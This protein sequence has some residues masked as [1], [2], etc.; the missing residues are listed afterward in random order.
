MDPDTRTVLITLKSKHTRSRFR[1][2][3]DAVLMTV[4]IKLISASSKILAI[5][6][7][8]PPVEAEPERP[9]TVVDLAAEIDAARAAFIRSVADKTWKKI[10]TSNDYMGERVVQTA[11]GLETTFVRE[12]TDATRE[13]VGCNEEF[14]VRAIALTLADAHPGLT[15]SVGKNDDKH[16]LIRV[17]VLHATPDTPV[18]L[19]I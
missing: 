12:L 2:W 10:C 8:A 18:L 4:G 3:L 14:Y 9:K 19:D 11:A 15:C 1:T 7:D 6:P 13:R 5:E 16:W 17:H